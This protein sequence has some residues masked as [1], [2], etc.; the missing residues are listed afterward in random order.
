MR[1]ARRRR[2]LIAK[3]RFANQQLQLAYRGERANQDYHPICMGGVEDK[4]A[5]ERQWQYRIA[6]WSAE[7]KL[8]SRALGITQLQ[9]AKYW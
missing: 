2:S 7:V 6:H 4:Y 5:G 1:Q 9:A 3:L 8:L